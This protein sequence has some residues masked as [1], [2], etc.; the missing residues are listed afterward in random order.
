MN[1]AP[2]RPD[3]KLEYSFDWSDW[4]DSGSPAE[5]IS[6]RA[7][8]ISPTGPTLTDATTDIVTVEDIEFGKTYRL[9]EVITT[10]FDQ[11]GARAITIRGVL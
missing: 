7:W 6:S 11:E 4:L 5:T 2:Q 8:T 9:Q 3:E 1:Y 10:S